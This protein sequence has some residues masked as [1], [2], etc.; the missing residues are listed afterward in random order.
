MAF[1]IRRNRKVNVMGVVRK[2][3]Y[4][5]LGLFVGAFLL[6]AI[7]DIVVAQNLAS[8]LWQGATVIGW[9]VNASN[10]VTA[11]SG[12]GILALVGVIGFLSIL[13]EFVTVR[14]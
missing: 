8:G 10:Q 12:T 2:M 11:T 9:T 7:G 3:A 6:D 13:M 1:S 4:T 5:I 14:F